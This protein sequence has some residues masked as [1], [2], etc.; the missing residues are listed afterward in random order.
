[1]LLFLIF[2]FKIGLRGSKSGVL[3]MFFGLIRLEMCLCF[4][5]SDGRIHIERFFGDN[6]LLKVGFLG[7]GPHAVMYN[8]RKL[9]ALC[10]VCGS[11]SSVGCWDRVIRKK[12]RLKVSR[13]SGFRGQFGLQMKKN[14]DRTG[15][16]TCVVSS[17]P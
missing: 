17:F 14:V 8:Y 10:K 15:C 2:F 1:M 9:Q 5:L 11:A 3:R 13:L 12:M 16:E 6:V 4:Y 7:F